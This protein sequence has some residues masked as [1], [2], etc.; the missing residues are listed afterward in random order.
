MTGL[1][2]ASLVILLIIGDSLSVLTSLDFIKDL[3]VS[4]LEGGLEVVTELVEASSSDSLLLAANLGSLLLDSGG[5][6]LGAGLDGL[7][8]GGSEGLGGGVESLHESLVLK[9]VLLAL[10]GDVGVDALHAE[11]AL[12]LVRVDD[13][14][15]VGARH[16]VSAELEAALLDGLLSVGTEDAIELVESILGEDDESAE[17]TTRSELEEVQSGDVAGVDTGEV[18]GSVLDVGAVITV[19]DQRSLA[20]S[21]ARV[22]HLALTGSQSLGGADTGEVTADTKS[23]EALEESGGLLLVEGVNNERELGDIVDLVTSGHDERTAG[24][25]GESG[26]NGVSLLGG[27]DLSVPLSPE[28]EGSEHATLTAHVTEGTLTGTVSTRARDS[29]DSSDGATGTPGLGGVLVASVPVDGM[30]LSSVFG[31]VGVAE[32]DEVVSDGGREDSGH[33]AGASNGTRLRGVS[34]D[35]RTGSH[36][37][38]LIQVQ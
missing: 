35:G 30:T 3:L 29:W 12:D 28:L 10:G 19:D 7:L 1:S 9:R 26:S 36:T 13:S 16:H 6:G 15:E 27:V 14:G 34:A 21:E 20:E 5:A 25:G 31:H 8:L 38:Y 22:T 17:V 18:S 33:G 23:G 37:V 2:K 4:I 32:L 24:G 11:L